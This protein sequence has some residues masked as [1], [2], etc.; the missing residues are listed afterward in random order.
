MFIEYPL[1][2]QLLEVNSPNPQQHPEEGNDYLH[3]TDKEID[4]E[5]LTNLL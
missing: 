3:L 4:P 2:A 5:K 1:C